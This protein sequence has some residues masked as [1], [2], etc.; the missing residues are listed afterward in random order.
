M[1]RNLTQPRARVFL[2][3]G[4]NKDSTESS[5]AA[6]IATILSNN[7]FDPYIA[8]QEQTLRGVTEN[9]YQQLKKSEYFIFIDFKREEIVVN[10]PDAT[11]RG[12]LFSHQELAI[13]S[14]LDIP[15]LALQERGV[16]ANDGILGF[17]QANAISFSD[18]DRHLLPSV[19]AAQIRERGWDPR[20][21]REITLERSPGEFTDPRVM[22]IP[23]APLG[24]FFH[25][26]ARNYHRDRAATNCYA[27]LTS[28]RNTNAGINIP[29][30]QTELKWAGYTFPN[31][32]IAAGSSRSIDAFW[33]RHADPTRLQFNMFTDASDYLPQ[34]AGA[35]DYELQYMVIADNFPP[36]HCAVMLHLDGL[37]DQTTLA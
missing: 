14:Y 25:I 30:P 8:I 1:A 23:G 19:V 37:L 13:A 15:V 27:Y 33:I 11:Y 12:S 6:A 10:G 5:T 4:Q 9:I 7:G 20:S 22:S 31:A 17:L 26:E 34:V 32:A 16:K 28:I 36:A 21:R 3:C 29:V 2:S 18:T 35:G 24:R